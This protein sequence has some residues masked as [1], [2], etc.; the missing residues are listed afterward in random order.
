MNLKKTLFSIFSLALVSLGIFI[1]ILF[2]IDPYKSDRFVHIAFLSSLFLSLA[3]IWV[4]TEYLIKI[5]L[6]NKELVYSI[7]PSTI[8]HAL[9]GSAGITLIVGLKMINVLNFLDTL[10]I[11]IIIAVSELYFKERPHAK[12]NQA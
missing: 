5:R 4:F 1:I 12:Q 7:L 6:N 9:L 8:R 3:G 10:I 11:L 2:N